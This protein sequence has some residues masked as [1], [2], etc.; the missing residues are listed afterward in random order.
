MSVSFNNVVVIGAGTMGSGI[1]AHLANAGMKVLLLDMVSEEGRRSAVA[2]AAIQRQMD[3]GGFMRPSFSLNVRA[4]NIA[5]DLNQVA[6]ADWIVEA[7][8]E[9]I[10][11]KKDL[12]RKIDALRKE[13]SIVSSNTSTIRLSQ[14]TAGLGD[15]FAA[16]FFI[17]H[18]F[19]PPRHMRL[20]ELVSSE[21]SNPRSLQT[22]RHTCDAVLGKTVIECRDMPGFIANRI[23]NYW[24]SVAALEAMRCGLTVEE[25]DLVLSEGFGV[26][27]TGVF[28]LFDLVGINLVPLVW[29]SLMSTLPD[30]DDHNRFDI[31]K[32]AF[33]S[34]MLRRGLLGRKTGGGF[35]RQRG[36]G[37]ERTREALDLS[38]GEY[39]IGRRPVL[40]ALAEHGKNLRKICQHD[41][42]AGRYAWSVLKNLINYAA[43]VTPEVTD[44]IVSVDVAMKLGYNWNVGPF[45]LADLVGSE[46]IVSRM[47]SEGEVIPYLLRAAAEGGGFYPQAGNQIRTS[48]GKAVP[49]PITAGILLLNNVKRGKLRVDGNASASLWDLGEGVLGVEVHTKMNACDGLVM[50]A[51]ERA[52]VLSEQEFN[53]I[54]V[55]NDHARAFSAG[56]NL[57]FFVEKMEQGDW[58]ALEQFVSLGQETF[59]ALSYSK[60]PVVAAG[61]GLA[62]GG[63]CELMVHCDEAVVHA[64]LNAGFPEL[65]VGIVP[66]WGGCKQMILRSGDDQDALLSAFKTLVTAKISSSAFEA[67][68]LGILAKTDQIVM[69]RDR[70]LAR[71]VARAKEMVTSGYRSSEKQSIRLGGDQSKHAMLH[72]VAPLLE[73]GYLSENDWAVVTELA[74]I[75]SG[76]QTDSKLVSQEEIS[77][78][79]RAAFM[80]LVRRHATLDRMKHM[81]ATGKALKN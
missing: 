29:A 16:D 51:I 47:E 64:E 24:M 75:F 28:G 1:A 65:N 12:Y 22:L 35:Y 67:K 81:L 49:R 10:D 7:I 37:T 77:L 9:D 62:L 19:N 66:G 8:V 13:G 32:N 70:L 73:G 41:S 79:E 26:P 55:G 21:K 56:A 33:F 2:E 71:A 60:V 34:Q 4:G 52:L 20:L 5:D 42:P 36:K 43:S 78:L 76:G 40:A 27:K 14:L 44:D 46:W 17:T 11:I 18:F 74:S 72:F 69:N 15:R 39:R 57:A 38:S 58:H 3:A 59:S 68:D 53:A 45:E 30:I 6:S 61:F 63:G 80:R 23:G 25:A 50:E 31:T 54:V 48:E